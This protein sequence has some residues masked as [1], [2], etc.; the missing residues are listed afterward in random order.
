LSGDGIFFVAC[1]LSAFD[2]SSIGTSIY[3]IPFK[4]IQFCSYHLHLIYIVIFMSLDITPNKSVTTCSSYALTECSMFSVRQNRD[5]CCRPKE[6]CMYYIALKDLSCVHV[7]ACSLVLSLIKI[8]QLDI[9]HN[10]LQL[11][12]IRSSKTFQARH[13]RNQYSIL[14]FK[15]RNG[16]VPVT[17]SQPL[18]AMKP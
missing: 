6:R 3:C 9:G 8:Y 14:Q 4:H 5:S 15:D 16:N 13:I 10:G 12:E 11:P 1:L 18:I 2:T 17:G 7:T